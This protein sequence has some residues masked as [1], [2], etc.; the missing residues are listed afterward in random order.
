MHIELRLSG[1]DRLLARLDSEA[2]PTIP[3]PGLW[4]E[5]NSQP[6]LVTQRRH[7]YALRGGRYHLTTVALEVKQQGRPDD[8]QWWNGQWVIGDPSCTFNAR[9][10]FLRCAVLPDGPCASCGH[11]TSQ[12]PSHRPSSQTT[13]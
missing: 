11:F 10:P 1:S 4:I 6:L 12:D 13:P 5:V 2:M 7:R 9:S 3:Q 8:A